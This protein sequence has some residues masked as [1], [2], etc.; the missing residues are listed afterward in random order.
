MIDTYS[1]HGRI[2]GGTRDEMIDAAF[3]AWLDARSAGESVVV[4][5]P[6]HATVDL[7]AARARDVRVAAGEVEEGGA[8]ASGQTVGV[9][10]EIVTC[11]NDRQL[12]TSRGLWVRNGDRWRITA[13]TPAGLAVEHLD[14]RGRAVLPTEYVADHVRLAY[15]LTVHK[16]QGLT[17]DHCV[18]VVDDRTAGEHAY[19]GLTRGRLDNRACVVCEPAEWGGPTPDARHVLAAAL[20]RS[21]ADLSATETLRGE[22]ARAE[23]LHVLYPAWL[24]VRDYIDTHA[25]PDRHVELDG[26]GE[27]A[28]E[29]RR[30]LR[31]LPIARRTFEDATAEMTRA[32]RSLGEAKA[33]VAALRKP[34]PW[35][36]KAEPVRHVTT[37]D[38]VAT[39][40]HWFDKAS[41]EVTRTA[42]VL[43]LVQ[44]DEPKLSKLEERAAS[45]TAAIERRQDWLD[46]HPTE[47]AWEADL[48]QRITA[49]A[50]ELGR[51]AAHHAPAHLVRLLGPVPP[52]EW[53]E[54]HEQWTRLAGRV[55]AYR[56]RWGVDGGRIGAEGS[57]RG[58]QARH[59]QRIEL[60][61][62]GAR[63]AIVAPPG[64][65]L[66]AGHTVV[67]AQTPDIGL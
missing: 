37:A 26:L 35:W 24:E 16:T 34:L 64:R 49:R 51:T 61:I 46:A 32:S 28:D 52:S 3:S 58:E 11:E 9:G 27:A 63:R 18:L 44:A 23:S 25:G 8:D 38:D 21:V 50:Q 53:I 65:T 36:R 29:L 62:D 41:A 48:R 40:R 31:Y 6:D 30:R 59:W 56:E 13:R 17:V 22:L 67:P 54:A 42:E 14:G 4:V 5:A 12:L 2:V 20:A 57:V 45:V 33:E 43:R 7:L 47:R 15:A 39:R 55:E 66:E 1:E 10:D 60:A 19:V